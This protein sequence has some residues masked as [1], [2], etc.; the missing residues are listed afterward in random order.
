MLPKQEPE[1]QTLF[2]RI[3]LKAN[4]KKAIKDQYFET[5]LEKEIIEILN[6]Y[7]E[8]KSKESIV[9]KDADLINQTILQCNYLKS[10]KKD[11]AK[12]NRHSAKGLKTKSA[13]ELVKTIATR[14]PFEWF[15]NFPDATN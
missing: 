14:S 8:R 1:T 12:W 6:E 10:S 13:K 11:L 9:A 2:I 3:I 15:Y 4:E 7:N 5:P